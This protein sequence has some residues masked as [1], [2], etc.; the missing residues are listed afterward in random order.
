MNVSTDSVLF[1]MPSS[2]AATA[3]SSLI[4]HPAGAGAGAS[5]SVAAGFGLADSC[6]TRRQ[7]S[8]KCQ[9]QSGKGQDRQELFH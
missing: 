2:S 1:M 6:S 8:A 7:T 4:A 3:S 9:Q 5:G